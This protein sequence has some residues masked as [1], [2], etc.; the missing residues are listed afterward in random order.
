VVEKRDHGCGWDKSVIKRERE[1]EHQRE[2]TRERERD[3]DSVRDGWSSQWKKTNTPKGTVYLKEIN[4]D[5]I[6]E[7]EK[8]KKQKTKQKQKEKEKK[9]RRRRWRKA[10]L[11]LPLSAKTEERRI[12]AWILAWLVWERNDAVRFWMN[13]KCFALSTNTTHQQMTGDKREETEGEGG[14][15]RWVFVGFVSTSMSSQRSNT[16]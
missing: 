9:K 11:A 7:R 6:L 14:V 16:K 5:S 2:S 13:A 8:T 4:R 1:R 10:K 12:A 15:R 3:V